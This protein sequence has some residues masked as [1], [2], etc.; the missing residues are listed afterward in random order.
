[1]FSSAIDVIETIIKDGLNSNQSAKANILTGLL[2][3]W[4]FFTILGWAI[5]C[6]TGPKYSK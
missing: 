1:M 3:L 4:A 2:L 6:S 5:S